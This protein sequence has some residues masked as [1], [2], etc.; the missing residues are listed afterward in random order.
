MPL[1]IDNPF[2]Q[3]SLRVYAAPGVSGECLE[4][5]DKLGA[6]INVMLYAVWLGAVRGITL[7]ESDFARMEEVAAIWASNVVLPLRKVRQGL[8]AMPEIADPQVQALRKRVADT[9]LFSEQIEQAMFFQLTG[10]IGKPGSAANAAAHQNILSV[11]ARYGADMN[12]FPLSNL[13]AAAN[14]ARD[15]GAHS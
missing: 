15:Q 11:L 10:K 14:A 5:Q 6:D 8:K 12:A 9:E 4:L 7:R 3:F 2:W 1:E 13:I